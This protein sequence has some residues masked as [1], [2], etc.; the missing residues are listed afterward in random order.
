V[1]VEDAP[2]F[3][4]Q[5]RLSHG[6]CLADAHCSGVITFRLYPS[7]SLLPSPTKRPLLPTEYDSVLAVFPIDLIVNIVYGNFCLISGK[8]DCF[9]LCV[10]T[11]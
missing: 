4:R 9:E 6:V 8:S 5:C 3:S 1:N 2:T 7:A 10:A 11:A